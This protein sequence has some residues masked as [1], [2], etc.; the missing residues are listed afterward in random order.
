VQSLSGSCYA[1]AL[2]AP[3]KLISSLTQDRIPL[4][5]DLICHRDP[6]PQRF[7]TRVSV[8]KA[9]RTHLEAQLRRLDGRDIPSRSTANDNHIIRV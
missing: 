6:R 7:P 4:N 8:R 2:R 3:G 9:T 1:L 5:S